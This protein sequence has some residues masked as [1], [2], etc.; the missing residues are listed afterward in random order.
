MVRTQTWNKELIKTLNCL[1]HGVSYSQL[2]EN[3]TAFCLEK[4]EGMGEGQSLMP[5]NLKPYVFTNLAWDNIDRFEEILSGKGT[6]HCDNGI[7]VRA[8]MFGPCLPTEQ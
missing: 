1:R 8:R 2:E 5:S 3:D 6:T 7:T 4:L